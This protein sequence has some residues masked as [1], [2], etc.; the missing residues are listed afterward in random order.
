MFYSLLLYGII[1]LI[2][3]NIPVRNKGGGQMDKTTYTLGGLS[4]R[5]YVSK[6]GS[7]GLNFRHFGT[8]E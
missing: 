2:F 5:K 6:G 1:D 3:K 7:V 8:S 4:K